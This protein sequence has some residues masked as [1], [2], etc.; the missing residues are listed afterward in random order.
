[1]PGAAFQLAGYRHVIGT[2]W[3]ISD[4]LAPD[5]AGHVYRALT[6]DGTAG[7]DTGHTAA[8]LDAAIRANRQRPPWL[9]APYIHL[10]P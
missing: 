7:L 9:W 1:L 5:V 3:S 6:H 2:L 4:K 10:G 8:A